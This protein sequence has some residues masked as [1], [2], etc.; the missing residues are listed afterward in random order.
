LKKIKIAKILLVDDC[1]EDIELVRLA[2]AKARLIL[3][4]DVVKDGEEALDYLF[5][6]K[7]ATE[8]SLPDL[9]FLDV[10]MPGMNGLEL[11]QRIKTDPSLKSIPVAMLTS[12]Q[13]DTDILKSYNQH[14]NCYL[15]KP[16]EFDSFTKMIENFNKFWFCIATLPTDVVP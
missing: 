9:I 15:Q 1:E 4:L 16:L 6:Q 5:K 13:E 3:D 11:L 10:N 8:F 2:F 7:E 12:S 14:A